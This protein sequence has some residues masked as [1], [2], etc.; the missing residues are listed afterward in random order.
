VLYA[1]VYCTVLCCAVLCC[2]VLCCAVLCCGLCCAVLCCAVLCCAVLCWAVGCGLCCAVLRAVLC[3]AQ[4]QEG[5]RIIYNDGE[6]C[7]A[8]GAPRVPRV[9][10]LGERHGTIATRRTATQRAMPC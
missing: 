9:T 1:N 4:G 7:E 2:A 5:V 6:I 8:P 10:I 3:W